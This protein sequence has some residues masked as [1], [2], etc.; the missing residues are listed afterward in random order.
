MSLVFGPT[1]ALAQ[2]VEIQVHHEREQ[3]FLAQAQVALLEQEI[4]PSV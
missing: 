1:R 2:G 3:P 4:A